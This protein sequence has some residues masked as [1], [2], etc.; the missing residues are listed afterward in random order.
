[1]D[2]TSE[3]NNTSELLKPEIERIISR[4]NFE[5]VLTYLSDVEF[6]TVT[7]ILQNGK[8]VQVE[9]LEKIRIS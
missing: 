3:N 4:E 6:G 8:V 1:M 7:L 9:K 5:K 2:M